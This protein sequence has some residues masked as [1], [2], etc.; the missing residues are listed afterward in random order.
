MPSLDTISPGA[1]AVVSLLSALGVS[2]EMHYTGESTPGPIVLPRTAM[3]RGPLNPNR[4]LG[5]PVLYRL[6]GTMLGRTRQWRIFARHYVGARPGDR[7]L[8]VGCGPADV[9]AELPTG[10]DYVGFDQSEH[11]IDSARR[12]H[13]A[14]GQF[15]AGTVDLALVDRLGA[16]SFDI[17]IAH[18]LLHHLDDRDATEFFALARAALRPGGR[19]VT[20]DGCYLVGQSRIAR[21]LL[22]MDRGRHVRTEEEY[23]ALASQSFAVPSAFV[24]HDSAYVPYTTVYLVCQA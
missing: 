10:I 23:V 19:L 8:D 9:M 6:L 18:G 11:Y 20:A 2:R 22:N 1:F 16:A 13:G 21:L 14:R 17:V 15:F 4:V 12:R 5:V 7:I 24:R 3:T